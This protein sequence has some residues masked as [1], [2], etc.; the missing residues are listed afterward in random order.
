MWFRVAGFEEVSFDG[1]PEPFGVGVNQLGPARRSD[2]PQ[3][4]RQ[5]F[6]F[7]EP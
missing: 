4:P 7:V 1:A 5:L 2:R 6:R 3:L